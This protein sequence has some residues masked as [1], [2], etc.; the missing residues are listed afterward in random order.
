M[1]VTLIGKSGIHKIVLPKTPIGNYWLCDNTHDKKTNLINIEGKNGNWQIITN[2]FVKAI[3]PRPLVIENDKIK[4]TPETEVVTEK[5]ILKE[6]NLYGVCIGDIEN[7]YIVYCAPTYENNFSQL[8]IRNT[9]EILIGK[10]EKNHIV[11]NNKLV[12]NTH[13]RIIFD[14]HNWILENFDKKFGTFIMGL[15]IIILGNSICINNPLSNMTYN[16][17]YLVAVNISRKID[18]NEEIKDDENLEIYEDKDYF[19]RSPRLINVI[20]KEKVKIDPPPSIQSDEHTPLALVLGSSMS[21]GVVMLVSATR[22]IDNYASGK[23]TSKDLIFQVVI[24]VAML[25]SMLLIPI[26]NVSYDKKRK[27]KREAKR[28]ERYR[29]YIDSKI[30]IIDEMM[31]KQRKILY[32]NNLSQDE[33]VSIILNKDTRLWERKKEDS[34]FLNV[35]L[36]IGDVPLEIDINYP[37]D[38]FKNQEELNAYIKSLILQLITFQSYEDLKLVF[39]LGEDKSKNW[40]YVKLLPHV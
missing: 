21:M 40:E 36:G 9:N 29:K 10:S 20:E 8:R 28:Q 37:E 1:L 33:C 5:I 18:E 27:K 32:E 17:K 11:Y 31:D 22:T 19:S 39:L 24:I 23:G 12:S 4:I 15:K 38:R 34:D 30:E 3:N 25:I 26:L 6:Y 35:R 2:K 14:D 16:K 13:A 7:F